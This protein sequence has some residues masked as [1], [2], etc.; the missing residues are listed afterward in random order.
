MEK[1]DFLKRLETEIKI[2]KMSDYTLR[3]YLNFNK[4]LL[5]HSKKNPNQIEQ[6]DIKY[7]LADKMN[8]RASA[9]TI[10]LGMK[11]KLLCLIDQFIQ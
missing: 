10:L 8:N 7:F 1:E 11:L 9:S 2:S 4:Q 3:N 5:E 6:Q